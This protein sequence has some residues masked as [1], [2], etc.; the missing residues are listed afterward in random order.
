MVG[1]TSTYG[2]VSIPYGEGKAV[3]DGRKRARSG[4]VSIPYGKGKDV[5]Q[6]DYEG[7]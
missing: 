2:I 7:G 5:P 3:T 1:T 6:R 4:C